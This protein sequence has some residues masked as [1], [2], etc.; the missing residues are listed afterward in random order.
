M[1]YT[2]AAEEKLAAWMKK[3]RAD[4]KDGNAAVISV[5]GTRSENAEE[6]ID[7]YIFGGRYADT[8]F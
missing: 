8:Q 2:D 3:A 4:R 5:G 7:N 6:E 1:E